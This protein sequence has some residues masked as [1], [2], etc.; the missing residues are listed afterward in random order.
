[1][2]RGREGRVSGFEVSGRGRENVSREG[3]RGQGG[4]VDGSERGERERE[5]EAPWEKETDS[6]GWREEGRHQGDL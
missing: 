1:M 5:A 3:G 6:Q 4:I 2:G